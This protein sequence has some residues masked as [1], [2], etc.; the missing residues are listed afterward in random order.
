[1]VPM[2]GIP[3]L[4][5]KSKSCMP[6]VIFFIHSRAGNSLGKPGFD[7]RP[8]QILVHLRFLLAQVMCLTWG[9]GARHGGATPLSVP[10]EWEVYSALVL[11]RN[12]TYQA[13]TSVLVGV[14]NCGSTKHG[15]VPWCGS[16][17]AEPA[18]MDNC[19]DAYATADPPGHLSMLGGST[20]A[21]NHQDRRS[22]FA[23]CPDTLV[24]TPGVC[25]P[26]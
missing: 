26:W 14:G 2:K 5:W 7:F 15:Q 10:G 13:W 19:L 22:P 9:G 8:P 21:S 18:S 12:R 16:T 25:L 3:Q 6:H 11:V 20:V 17:I 24:S 1:M 23:S 4:G